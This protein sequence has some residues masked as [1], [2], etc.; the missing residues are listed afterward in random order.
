M[1]PKNLFQITNVRIVEWILKGNNRKGIK[2]PLEL[3]K[4]RIIGHRINGC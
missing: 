3:E 2:N 1:G 4:V